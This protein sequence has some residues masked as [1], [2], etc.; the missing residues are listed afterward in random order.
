MFQTAQDLRPAHFILV[1]TLLVAT[2]A[3]LVSLGSMVPARQAS[4]TAWN[5]KVSLQ[6]RA[7]VCNSKATWVWVEAS[8]GER[9]WATQPGGNYRFDFKR[10]PTGG[11]T[12]TV[13]LGN[14]AC[15]RS[16]TFGLNRPTFG[17]SA[18]RNVNVLL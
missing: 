12:V 5:P 14:S 3:V 11:M 17:T 10:V 16:S 13:K 4:A 7:L 8:N 9:G 2:F 18:T 6:G 1:K 15:D